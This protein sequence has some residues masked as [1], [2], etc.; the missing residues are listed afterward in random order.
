MSELLAVVGYEYN[1]HTTTTE[2]ARKLVSNE[3]QTI[4]KFKAEKNVEALQ[5]ADK[6]NCRKINKASP[7]EPYQ[8]ILTFLEKR[9]I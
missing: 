2:A 7:D 4:N 3:M 6:T 5:Y 8:D 1:N 9:W